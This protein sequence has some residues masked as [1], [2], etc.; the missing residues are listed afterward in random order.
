[1]KTQL[2]RFG[3]D[4]S[5]VGGWVAAVAAAMAC[6]AAATTY[7]AV[8]AVVGLRD[9]TLST[10]PQESVSFLRVLDPSEQLVQEAQSAPLLDDPSIAVLVDAMST[11]AR[12]YL[13]LPVSAFVSDAMARTDGTVPDA[14]VVAGSDPAF[15]PSVPDAGTGLLWG[16]LGSGGAPLVDDTHL[17]ALTL[18]TMG[19]SNLGGTFIAGDGRRVALDAAPLV[20]VSIPQLRSLGL[21]SYQ[22]PSDLVASVTCSCAESELSPVASAMTAASGG[23]AVFY[24]L[25]YEGLVGPSQRQSSVSEV[26]DALQGVAATLGL[27]CLAAMTG[28][29]LWRRRSG[30]Y[31]VEIICGAGELGLQVRLQALVAMS[32]TVP[33]LVGFGAAHQMIATTA[34]PPPLPARGIGLVIAVVVA[35]HVAVAYPLVRS[36]HELFRH[37]LEGP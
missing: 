22:R 20:A 27:V 21:S 37:P 23:T 5:D 29:I 31:R 12:M 28:L 13:T 30:S 8:F 14:I 26:L 3:R 7:M 11:D 24:A 17:A 18:Q 15:L 34:W 19:T 4:L 33:C 32:I 16:R 36:M 2:E 9:G 25:G 10:R 35:L 6:V 1:M